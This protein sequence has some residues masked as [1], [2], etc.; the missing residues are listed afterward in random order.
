MTVPAVSSSLSSLDES[1]SASSSTITPSAVTHKE[2]A[3]GASVQAEPKT[4]DITGTSSFSLHLL[5]TDLI[6]S[7]NGTV[8]TAVAHV[9]R[10]SPNNHKNTSLCFLHPLSL[11]VCSSVCL[12]LFELRTVQY[13]HKVHWKASESLFRLSDKILHNYWTYS[14]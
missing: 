11:T 5:S 2:E 8:F 9:T 7:K 6:H 13:M 4:E 10:D 12:P 14:Q 1:L 3:S